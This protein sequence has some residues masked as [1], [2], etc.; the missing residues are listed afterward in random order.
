[1][2][3]NGIAIVRGGNAITFLGKFVVDESILKKNTPKITYP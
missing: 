3:R 1:M 2:K